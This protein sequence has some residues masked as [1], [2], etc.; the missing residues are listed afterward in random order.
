MTTDDST[1]RIYLPGERGDA[2]LEQRMREGIPLPQGT[3]SK[4][5]AVAKE[6]GVDAY[7]G[8]PYQEDELLRNLR[9][10]LALHTA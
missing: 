8:K 7:L 1:E 6:L 10:L 9:E 5:L 2:I 3:W 4:L